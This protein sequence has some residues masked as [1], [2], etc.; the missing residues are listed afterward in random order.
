MEKILN[1]NKQWIDEIWEKIDSKMKVVSERSKNKIPYTTINGV[2]DDRAENDVTWWTNGFWGGMMWLLYAGTK[3]EHY[4][5][6]ARNAQTLLDKAFEDY[7]GLHHDVGFMW[8]ISSGADYRLTGDKGA[9][10]RALMA[11]SILASRY[12]IDGKYIRSWNAWNQEDPSEHAGWV[13]IDCMMN[14]PLLYWASK[15]IGDP[16]FKRI[17]T[18]HA[19]TVLKTHIRPDGSVVHI[20]DLDTETGDFKESFGGQGYEVGS[21]WT[22]GQSWAIYGYVLSYIHTGNQEYL[23]AAKRVAHYFVA[24]LLDDFV[25][26]IDFRA[27][28]EPKTYDTTAGA[29]AA[30]GLIEIAK[31][32]PEYEKKM[33]INA[34]IKIL[35]AMEKDHCNW[36]LD[37]DSI[38]QNGSEA[39]HANKDRNHIPIIYG[40]YYFIEAIYKL[41]GFEPLFW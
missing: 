2:H 24:N 21:S 10:T 1:E 3:D 11:A 13:I 15:E 41:K 7:D 8:H 40:D 14:V 38:L 18:T 22:R 25:P 31:C 33:Y 23:D 29:C 6:V 32:V 19:D 12:N 27:P 36:T 28:E 39:Y 4:K 30:C 26:P 37:E 34:A 35:K 20:A 9:R 16:R 5:E 17:A